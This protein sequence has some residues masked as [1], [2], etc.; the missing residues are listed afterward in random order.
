MHPTAAT[1][2]FWVTASAALLGAGLMVSA[3]G[4]KGDDQPLSRFACRCTFLT[5]TDGTSEQRVE[6]CATAVEAAN[7]EA[8]GCAQS[9]APAPIQ[10][11]Q[12]ESIAKTGPCPPKTCQVHER[13]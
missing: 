7:S 3:G 11:C 13:R 10:G 12:C 8:E 5:D 4:C 6:V 1:L 9:A 2:R